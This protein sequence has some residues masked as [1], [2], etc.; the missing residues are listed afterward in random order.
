MTLPVPT[1]RHAPP[2]STL[3]LAC[4]AAAGLACAPDDS[5]PAASFAEGCVLNTADACDDCLEL[6]GVFRIG[7]VDGPGFISGRGGED[8]IVRDGAGNF[9]LGQ[10]DYMN[11]YGPDGAFIRSVGSQG[12]GPMEF[13]RAYPFHADAAG[14]VHVWDPHNLRVSIISPAF[15]LVDERPITGQQINDMMALDDGDL[16][17]MQTWSRDP[18]NPGQPLHIVDGRDVLVSFGAEYGPG[19]D[20]LGFNPVDERYAAITPDGSIMVAHQREYRI[21]AWSRDG[22]LLGSLA[23]PDLGSTQFEPGEVTPDN[24]LPNQ[25]VD[26]HVDASGRVWVSRLDRRADWVDRSEEDPQGGLMPVDMDIL[27]WFRTRIDLIDVETCTMLAS[28]VQDPFFLDF[29]EDG[30]VSDVEFTPEGAPLVNLKRIGMRDGAGAPEDD[31]PAQASAPAEEMAA[32]AEESA[33]GWRVDLNV[34][35][36]RDTMG[37]A[38]SPYAPAPEALSGA[39]DDFSAT[40]RYLCLNA[41]ER[42]L[43]NV[44]PVMILFQTAPRLVMAE[45][46]QAGEYGQIPLELRANWGGEEVAFNAFYSRRVSFE[47]EDGAGRE[48]RREFARGVRPAPAGERFDGG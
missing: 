36:P 7:S 19:D 22:R 13:E 10:R 6:E 3:W 42:E 11:V 28:H 5:Q 15:E 33:T 38:W 21:E 46:G 1:R 48:I 27:N 43:G 41:R 23:G 37:N 12:E 39:Q 30:L 45:G 16:Y 47:Q 35:H 2:R 18:A 20:P 44:A 26:L 31:P 32:V 34:D 14:N 4:L 8:Q 25:L 29:V 17:V 24:P 40:I 9:W